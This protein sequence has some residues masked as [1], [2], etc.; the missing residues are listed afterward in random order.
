M[1]FKVKD[2]EQVRTVLVPKA[3]ETVLKAGDLVALDDGLAILAVAGSDNVGFTAEGAGAGEGFVN[4]SVGND[5]TLVG[6]A[7]ANFA[8]AH[9]GNTYDIVESTGAQT[10]NQSGTTKNVL[11]V[12]ISKDTGTVGSKDNIEVRIEKPLF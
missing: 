4:V 1:N 7:G 10:I 8:A 11:R 2:G 6:T 9:R 3:S 12:G 5:F